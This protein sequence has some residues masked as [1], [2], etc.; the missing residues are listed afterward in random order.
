[1][2]WYVDYYLGYKTKDGKIYPLGHFDCFGNLHSV[3]TKSRSYASDLWER[4]ERVTLEETTDELRAHFPSGDIYSWEETPEEEKGAI[5]LWC[6]WLPLEDLPVGS[7]LKQGYYL[8]EDINRYERSLVDDRVYFDGFYH[9]LT[10]AE[11]ARKMESELKF[12]VPKPKKDDFGEEF[13][14]Y[15]C[16]E[17]SFYI[18]PDTDSMEY[19]AAMIRQ[20][21]SVYEFLT[22]LPEG[23]EIVVL[24]TNG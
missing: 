13:E 6:F 15:S 5:P 19:E 2:S 10:P 3:L 4:F 9:M 17:Y 24:Q 21:A 1:M 12:G 11:Y 7:Y 14:V 16:G 23:S 20:A 18:Y 8:Q 22:D